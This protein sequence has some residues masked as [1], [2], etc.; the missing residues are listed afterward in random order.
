[1]EQSWFPPL[2]KMLCIHALIR[3]DY[4]ECLIKHSNP[5]CFEPLFHF[6]IYAEHADSTAGRLRKKKK[7]VVQ[8]YVAM[9][10]YSVT[11]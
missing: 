9:C 3:K 8:S 11:V 7:K 2:I 10:S 5:G 4:F 1:M 6:I